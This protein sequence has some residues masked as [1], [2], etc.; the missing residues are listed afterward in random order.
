MA[1]AW[2]GRPKPRARGPKAR[3][4]RPGQARRPLEPKQISHWLAA[5]YDNEGMNAS[6]EN[7]AR[8]IR[9]RG[10]S[11]AIS[12]QLRGRPRPA[13]RGPAPT[14]ASRASRP[15]DDLR[16]AAGGGLDRA[17]PPGKGDLI[18]GAA[19][20][21][22]PLVEGRAGTSSCCTCPTATAPARCRGA[23]SGRW[24][25]FP[26]PWNSAAVGPGAREM[27]LHGKIS[28]GAGHG[29]LLL[30]PALAGGAAPTERPAGST[31]RRELE[32]EHL[33]RGP[34]RVDEEL[35]DRPRKTL[36]WRKPNEVFWVDKRFADSLK[37][38][39]LR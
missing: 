11:S 23:S 14:C 34:G 32:P 15:G 25:G 16:A 18:T 27:A 9:R 39:V 35:N 5:E 37:S 20:N 12:Q 3:G 26:S 24:R 6:T 2:A 4:G 13:D 31:S 22:W 28:G 10:S 29:R 7:H 21:A 17:V 19:N 8:P 1:A 36:G 38:A 33:S 30:R